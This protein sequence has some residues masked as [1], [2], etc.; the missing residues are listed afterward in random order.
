MFDGTE[1]GWVFSNVFYKGFSGK[2]A[3]KPD[4]IISTHF[5]FSSATSAVAPDFSVVGFQSINI[6]FKYTALNGDI[7][8]WKQYLADQYAAGT[9]VIIVYPLETPTTETVAGQTMNIQA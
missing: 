2:T 8:A 3:Y 7:N 9:P 5:N 1:D 4:T 6:G